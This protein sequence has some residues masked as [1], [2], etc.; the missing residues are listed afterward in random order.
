MRQVL[1]GQMG[2]MSELFCIGFI[3]LNTFDTFRISKWKNSHRTVIDRLRVLVP[4]SK[5]Q[6]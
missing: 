6:N 3:L 2:K 1:N 4:S 5:A